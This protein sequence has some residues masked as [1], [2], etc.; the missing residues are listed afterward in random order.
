[1]KSMK[2]LLVGI[3][4]TLALFGAHAADAKAVR[5]LLGI[6]LTFGGETLATVPFSDGSIE[7]IQSGGLLAIYGGAEFRI[8]DQLSLQTTIGYHVDDTK[9]ASNGGLRFSRY[10]IDIVALY[11]A[12][13][14]VRLGLGLQHVSGP[15]LA[16]S[17]VASNIAIDFESSTGVI[18]EGE[19]LFSPNVGLK[20][21]AVTHTF[22]AKGGS[23]DIDGNHFGLM[24]KYYF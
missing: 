2:T 16:G 14:K 5:P 22:K 1:M 18:V 9:A 13:D 23:A 17:G 8:G 7:K 12:A 6:G 24:L 4:L 11:G 19:Y 20:A 3:A 10:P 15:K 21:R